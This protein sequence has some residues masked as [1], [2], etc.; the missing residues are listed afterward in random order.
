MRKIIL[1]LAVS[2]DG[3]IEGPGGEIDWCIFEDDGSDFEEF[4]DS[5]D[6]VFYGRVSYDLW[7]NWNPDDSA[8]AF[9]QKIYRKIHQKKKYVFSHRDDYNP[10]DVTVIRYDAVKN[11]KAITQRE[12][13]NI[14]LFGGADLITSFMNE[15]LI[16]V[17]RL[18]VHPVILGGGKAL[19][20]S[21]QERKNLRLVSS[22]P[23]NSG[24]LFLI[25][26]IKRK[27]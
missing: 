19:F 3:F 17:I 2:L 12:G 7:G 13:K 16:D 11:V 18:A 21:I 20:S 15:D 10:G 24:L 8:G 1:D 26:E 9:L 14:W 5:I 23:S 4:I 22:T 25:Y 27:S 6:A